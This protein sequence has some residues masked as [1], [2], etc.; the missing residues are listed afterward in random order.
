MYFFVPYQLTGIQQGIQAGHAA[1]EYANRFH[2]SELFQDFI[3]NHKTWVILN[4]GTTNVGYQGEGKGT[5]DLIWTSLINYNVSAR[6]DDKIDAERFH[7]PDLNNAMTAVCFIC[8]EQVFNRELYPD[9][10][11]SGFD[12]KL[13]SND[14][15]KFRAMRNDYKSLKEEY[16]GYHEEWEKSIG[17]PR[18][19]FLK[20]LLNGKK[21]A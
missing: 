19:S 7:E 9:F 2:N 18:N 20:E 5:L 8:D 14:R 1:L 16:G 15:I 12:W 10:K 3:N 17:G 13:S 6:L 21:L 4:G 11:D